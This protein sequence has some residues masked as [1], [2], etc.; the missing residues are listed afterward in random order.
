MG[1]PFGVNN[2]FVRVVEGAP[3]EQAINE[4]LA[5]AIRGGA[6]LV[7]MSVFGADDATGKVILLFEGRAEGPKRVA[8]D[9][10]VIGT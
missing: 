4:A 8:N 10:S 7:S 1:Y 2:P 3:D 6:R 5:H 9:T